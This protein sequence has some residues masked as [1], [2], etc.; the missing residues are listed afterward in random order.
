MKEIALQNKKMNRVVYRFVL[1]STLL[2][3]TM[4][5]TTI[6]KDKV[7]TGLGQKNIVKGQIQ[8]P[9]LGFVGWLNSSSNKSEHFTVQ[10]RTAR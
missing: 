1:A 4:S 8:F 10:N 5:N 3:A 6:F 9:V 7:A 2:L